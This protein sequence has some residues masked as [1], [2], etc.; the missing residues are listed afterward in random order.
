MVGETG[1][2]GVAADE[3]QVVRVKRA[4]RSIH[5]AP[6]PKIEGFDGVRRPPGC[7]PSG[8]TNFLGGRRPEG[9]TLAT[10]RWAAGAP[11]RYST[12]RPQALTRR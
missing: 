8:R 9:L 11:L 2:V 6:L 5:V 12:L 3:Y 10:R 1:T 7:G 4:Y